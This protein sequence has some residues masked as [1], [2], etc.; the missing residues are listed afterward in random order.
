MSGNYTA[1][2]QWRPFNFPVNVGLNLDSPG[3]GLRKAVNIDVVPGGLRTRHGHRPISSSFETI[4][5]NLGGLFQLPSGDLLFVNDGDLLKTDSTTPGE[6]DFTTTSSLGTGYATGDW[7]FASLNDRLAVGV[8]VDG[9][10]NVWTNGVDVFNNGVSAPSAPTSVEASSWSISAG[11]YQVRV[12]Y[13][14]GVTYETDASLATDVT[15]TVGSKKIVVTTTASGDS[16]IDGISIYVTGSGGSTAYLQLLVANASTTHDVTVINLTTQAHPT[17]NGVPPSSKH[18]TAAHNRVFYGSGSTVH[19]SAINQASQVA[20]ASF[21]TFNP[22]NG[23][24]IVRLSN[25]QDFIVVFKEVGIYLLNGFGAGNRTDVSSTDGCAATNSVQVMEDNRGVIFLSNDLSVK[26]LQGRQIQNITGGPNLDYSLSFFFQRSIDQSRLE[27]VRSAYVPGRYRIILP[28]IG[29]GHRQFVWSRSAWTEYIDDYY[30]KI[31]MATHSNKKVLVSVSLRGTAASF[32][33]HD[34]DVS[35]DRGQPIPTDVWWNYIALDGNPGSVKTPRRGY[36]T[37][38]AYR[39]FFGSGVDLEKWGF[40]LDAERNDS[41]EADPF[42]SGSDIF[43]TEDPAHQ[44]HKAF[45]GNPSTHWASEDQGATFGIGLSFGPDAWLFGDVVPLVFVQ[46]F[47]REEYIGWDFVSTKLIEGFEFRPS[48]ASGGIKDFEFQVSSDNLIWTTIHSG[49][50]HYSDTYSFAFNQTSCRYIRF[51]IT[52]VWEGSQAA[53]RNV[54]VLASEDV[55]LQAYIFSQ[56]P[57]SFIRKI[58]FRNYTDMNNFV[59]QFKTAYPNWMSDYYVSLA[60]FDISSNASISSSLGFITEGQLNQVDG[61]G[62]MIDMEEMY[63]RDAVL[64]LFANW[65]SASAI[66]VTMRL[67]KDSVESPVVTDTIV[68]HTVTLLPNEDGWGLEGTPTEVS[69]DGK[70]VQH[71]VRLSQSSDSIVYIRGVDVWFLPGELRGE[72]V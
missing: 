19:W 46:E 36:F 14:G 56:V 22:S 47:S 17:D 43:S 31:S 61:S 29:G 7:E 66:N 5:T 1:P 3:S 6:V 58:Y 11:N 37:L 18:I 44:G 30:E 55:Q 65:G 48:S 70:D 60:D 23:G 64:T 68:A 63:G 67:Y 4:D 51:L 39:D 34:E 59:A 12:T 49:S 20:P 13:T 2:S 26:V 8:S 50:S 15:V 16:Q 40:L 71:S 42:G 25:Y 21:Q 32:Y 57:G 9:A 27:E 10:D 33:I 53:L 28:V 62:N 41:I 38:Q 52:S 45:D 69:L 24:E 72:R 35:L 54:L